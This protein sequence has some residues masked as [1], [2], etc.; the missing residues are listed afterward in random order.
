M[1]APLGPP[2][3]ALRD[4][5]LPAGRGP[6]ALERALDNVLDIAIEW[7]PRRA[8]EVRLA[9]GRLTVRDRGPGIAEAD[10]PHVF[11]RF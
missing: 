6:L 2:F 7:S 5:A 11:D 1:R 4:R 9:D 3:R 8:S 10:L